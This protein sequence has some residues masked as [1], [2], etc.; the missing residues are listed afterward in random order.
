MMLFKYNKDS[1]SGSGVV[2]CGEKDGMTDKQTDRYNRANG[3]IFLLIFI[4][5]LA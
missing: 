1:F 5:I 2:I 4:A 3:P